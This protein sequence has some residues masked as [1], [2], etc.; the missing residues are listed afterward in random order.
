VL[1]FLFLLLKK[2]VGAVAQKS[3]LYLPL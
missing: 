1:G 2:E 3:C